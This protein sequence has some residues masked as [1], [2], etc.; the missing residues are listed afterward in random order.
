MIAFCKDSPAREIIIVTEAGMLHRLKKE[1]PHK[2]FIPVRP[3]I[4]S[5]ANAGS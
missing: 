3:R 4:V 5:V 1:I 2:T